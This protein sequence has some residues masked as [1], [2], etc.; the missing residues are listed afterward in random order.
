[1]CSS[2]LDACRIGLVP[3]TEVTHQD[4]VSVFNSFL[5][6]SEL[7]P[8]G[9]ATLSSSFFTFLC[10]SLFLA[11]LYLE[12]KVQIFACPCDQFANQGA[13]RVGTAVSPV[14][15]ARGHLR[16]LGSAWGLLEASALDTGL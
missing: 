16:Q 1:M 13:I 5:P 14:L 8:L 6:Q 15:Q 10:L 7:L 9:L 3:V 11:S 12:K 2:S 4:T